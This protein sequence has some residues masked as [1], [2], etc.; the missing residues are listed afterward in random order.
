MAQ[1]VFFCSLKLGEREGIDTGQQ[2]ASYPG[3]PRFY[4]LYTENEAGKMLSG[5][6]IVE[7]DVNLV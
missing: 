5:F 4:A 1:G 3:K 6:D 2:A 7:W